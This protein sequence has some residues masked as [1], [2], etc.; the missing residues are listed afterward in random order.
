MSVI[1]YRQ[2][3]DGVIFLTFKDETIQ[4]IM[5]HHMRF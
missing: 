1:Y 2:N 4:E 3:N 5:K